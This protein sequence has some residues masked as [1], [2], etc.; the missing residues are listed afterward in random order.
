M[1]SS[2][3]ISTSFPSRS[4]ATPP[5]RHLIL[6]RKFPTRYLCVIDTAQFLHC[7]P[8]SDLLLA[9]LF[10]PHT[11]FQRVCPCYTHPLTFRIYRRT[12]HFLRSGTLV[13]PGAS[14]VLPMAG[15]MLL[16][17]PKLLYHAALLLVVP[18][19]AASRKP[20]QPLNFLYGL[21]LS[22]TSIAN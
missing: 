13:P 8:I 15:L 1:C 22:F 16:H 11:A 19:P 3:I 20:G 9:F 12:S 7:L 18:L 14:T 4:T 17:F 21:N 10:L 2:G 5:F 6:V